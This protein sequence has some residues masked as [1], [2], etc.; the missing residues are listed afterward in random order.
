MK[1]RWSLD[2]PL[3]RRDGPERTG[4]VELCGGSSGTSGVIAPDTD[5]DTLTVAGSGVDPDG[6]DTIA[7]LIG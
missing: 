3:P 5:G 6:P 2:A 4:T 7:F 1:F